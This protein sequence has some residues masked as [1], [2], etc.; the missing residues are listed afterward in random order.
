MSDTQIVWLRRDLRMADNPAL[1]EAAKRGPVVAV[2]V[3]D[4]AVAK[5]HAYGG[6]SR[7]WL[8]HS[9][10]SLQASYANRHAKIVLRRGDA[11]EELL[12]LAKETGA[13]TIHA[14]RHYEPWWRNAEKALGEQ[15][16]LQRYDDANFLTVMG[17]IQTGTGGQY[18]IYTPF[19]RAVRAQFPPRDALPEPEKLSSPDTWPVSDDLADWDLLPTKPDWSGG[20]AEAWEV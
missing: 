19:S 11:V 7:W 8:H 6:A 4:D 13:T 2:F 15:I 14:N 18:K 5:T 16:D 9:L 17:S 12:N 10:E 1:F 3:L 20:I